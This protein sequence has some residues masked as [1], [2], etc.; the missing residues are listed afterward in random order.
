MPTTPGLTWLGKLVVV[1][2]VGACLYGA[3]WFLYGEGSLPGLGGPTPG[4]K[5]SSSAAPA[6]SALKI[7][8]AFGTEKK[9]WLKWAVERFAETPEGKHIQID[10]IPMGSLEGAQ[11]ILRGDERVHV[12]S[13]ASSVYKDVF[14]QEWQVQRGGDPILRE[15]ALALTPMVFVMWEARYQAFVKRYGELSFATIAQG[16]AERGGWAT[17]ADKPEWGLF[18]FGHTHPNL[19]NS[20]L[21][22]LLLMAYH[23]SDKCR[24]LKLA[25]I[26]DAHFQDWLYAV[27]AGVTGLSNSTGNMMR[28]M[29]LKGPS[30]FDALFVYENVAIDYLKNAEGRWGTLHVEYPVRNMW[31]DNPYYIVDVPWSDAAHRKA[32]GQFLDFLLSEPVQQQALVHGFRPGNPSVPIKGPDSPFT[33]YAKYGVRVDLATTCEPPGAEVINNL[34]ATWQRSQGRR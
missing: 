18:K 20:G 28:E 15:E 25:D 16:L 32:A 17:I 7:G 23:R 31:N 5:T 12:W 26:L 21:M 24:D 11:A 13:P 14:V 30:S 8:I 29:V 3:Y 6:P 1:A 10:L 22:T 27:E 33:R 4:P 19:S 34:L 9:R 2:F